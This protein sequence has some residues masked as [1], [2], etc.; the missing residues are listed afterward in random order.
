MW[1][2]VLGGEI[3]RTLL[4]NRKAAKLGPIICACYTNHA[5]DQLLE[6]ILA[7]GV[8]QVIRL[9]SRSKSELLQSSILYNVAQGAVP[10]KTE[11]HNRWQYNRDI[12][13]S[14]NEVED[15]L[16]ALENLHSWTNI[17]THL[18]KTN[19]EHLQKLFEMDEDDDDGFQAV[20]GEQEAPV[21][22]FEIV[23]GDRDLEELE[24]QGLHE[25]QQTPHQEPTVQVQKKTLLRAIRLA[26][27]ENFQGKEAQV[28][29]I[30]EVRS[31]DERKRGFLK[32]SNR[33]N[34]LLSRARHGMFIIGNAETARPVPMW[35]K[36]LSILESSN[37]IGPGLGLLFSNVA[38]P[39]RSRLIN[40]TEAIL[41][42]FLSE[43]K[44]TTAA[45][46]TK[47]RIDLSANRKDCEELIA[48]SHAKHQPASKAEGHPYWAHFLAFERSFAASAPNLTRLFETAR[49]YLWHAR[50]LCD[51]Y[52]G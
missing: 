35:T 17:H 20:R 39:G 31:N 9:R 15:K 11:K 33:I 30:S 29:V 22:A 47:V 28:I 44:V 24:A 42:A 14:S 51:N 19:H 25:T 4:Q 48:E 34:I 8:K 7:D 10:T 45:S 50:S 41:S 49:E 36:V 18:A 12:D 43:L 21:N 1:Q 40:I 52:P 5:L 16:S 6:H 13:I 32:T 23:N 26:S 46:S 3:L 27:V 37:N 38:L 2:V